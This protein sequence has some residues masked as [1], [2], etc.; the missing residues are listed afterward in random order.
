MSPLF[1][2]KEAPQ[3]VEMV[4][5]VCHS[6]VAL[7]ASRDLW[8]EQEKRAALI[9]AILI[10]VFVLCWTPFFLMELSSSLCACSL[11]T[12]RSIFLWLDYSNSFFNPLIYTAFNENY[13]NAFKSLFSKQRY[14]QCLERHTQSCGWELAFLPF[15]SPPG[16]FPHS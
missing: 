5:M 8:Q 13:N 9:V 15:P 11:P 16:A 6:M 3:E 4:F 12:W 7:E 2:T 1:Q 14:T 10:G